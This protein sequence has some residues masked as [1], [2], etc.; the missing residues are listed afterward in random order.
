MLSTLRVCC[1]CVGPVISLKEQQKETRWNECLGHFCIEVRGARPVT[2][3]IT[4]CQENKISDFFLFQAFLQFH[5]TTIMRLSTV[6]FNKYTQ[7]VQPTITSAR[8]YNLSTNFDSCSCAVMGLS[9][10]TLSFIEFAG[11]GD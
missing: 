4:L 5:L 6:R 7:N 3:F 1:P 2:S 11:S 8:N 9:P 10:S